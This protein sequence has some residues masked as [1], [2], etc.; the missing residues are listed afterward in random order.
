MSEKVDWLEISLTYF[1]ST[2]KYYSEDS[3]L[4]PNN[5]TMY[6]RRKYLEEHI[7]QIRGNEKFTYVSLDSNVLGYPFMRVALEDWYKD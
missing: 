6:E 3:V 4:I 2:G 5:L 7:S 1:K